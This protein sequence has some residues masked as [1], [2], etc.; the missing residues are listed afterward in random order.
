MRCVHLCQVVQLRG[1]LLVACVVSVIRS[2]RS[3]SRRGR[4]ALSAPADSRLFIFM[5]EAGRRTYLFIGFLPVSYEQFNDSCLF[6]K[7][8]ASTLNQQ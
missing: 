6:G 8:P 1:L 4:T 7:G 2:L 3:L 5:R